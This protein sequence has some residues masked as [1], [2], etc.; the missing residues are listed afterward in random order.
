MLSQSK[1]QAQQQIFFQQNPTNFTTLK[2]L[3]ARLAPAI[4][5]IRLCIL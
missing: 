3:M 4:Y 2:V 1:V 5:C